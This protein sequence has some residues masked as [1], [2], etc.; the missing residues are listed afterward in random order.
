MGVTKRE[1]RKV[2]PWMAFWRTPMTGVQKSKFFATEEEAIAYEQLMM[3]AKQREIKDRRATESG[4]KNTKKYT[5]EQVLKAYLA[6]V[7]KSE[8]SIKQERYHK[9][10]VV[11]VLGRRL[12]HCI[13]G[14]AI[15]LF[16]QAQRAR[17]VSPLTIARRLSVLRSALKWAHENRLLQGNPAVGVRLPKGRAKR[18]AP[19]TPAEAA[20]IMAVAAPHV[21]RAVLLGLFLGARVGPSEL[22]RI[23]WN[24]VDF[25]NATVRI[26]SAAKNPE[27]PWRD[28]PI[29]TSLLPVLRIWH[30][31]DGGAG[32]LIHW[33]RKPVRSI[34]RG[35]KTALLRAG[36]CRR[37]RPYDLRHAFA[38]YSLENGAD[39][40]ALA[41][42]M[43]H[44]DATMILRTYQH[45]QDSQRRAVVEAV[46]DIL[47]LPG[48]R[49]RYRRKERAK[50]L[51][52][53]D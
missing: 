17:G 49:K 20:R 2:R 3:D 35:W 44:K 13:N 32:P 5:V 37:I 1:D 12:A 42:I 14:D 34:H 48:W 47:D 22:F 26:W 52:C 28:V 27:R 16:V 40:K 30:D 45:V 23:T 33:A 11:K 15:M 50:Q 7:D 53:A 21:A 51:A 43:G 36:I 31:A 24:D 38:S 19:P 6:N 41:E 8:V 10:Q 9:D 18:F 46:P 4:Q 29:R 39:I 25:D